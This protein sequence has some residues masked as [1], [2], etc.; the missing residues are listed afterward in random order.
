MTLKRKNDSHSVLSESPQ[1]DIFR[2]GDP[3]V[4]P[5]ALGC[6]R[7]SEHSTQDSDK[8]FQSL[9][10][11]VFHWELSKEEVKALP[12]G[13]K[14]LNNVFP[15]CHNIRLVIIT[16]GESYFCPFTCLACAVKHIFCWGHR[17]SSQ[18]GP[19]GTVQLGIAQEGYG[20]H[21]CGQSGLS[22]GSGDFSGGLKDKQGQPGT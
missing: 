6:F 4:T 16:K 21:L 1:A 17:S 3:G 10:L 20:P 5:C 18:P 19:L 9:G 8:G 2:F 13:Q 7:S 15:S 22:W 11:C 14:D 12:Q